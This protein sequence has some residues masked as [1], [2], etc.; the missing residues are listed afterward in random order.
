MIDDKRPVEEMRIEKAQNLADA[1]VYANRQFDGRNPWWRGH[2]LS[3]WA[4]R[5]SIYRV[6]DSGYAGDSRSAIKRA[7]AGMVTAAWETPLM[8]L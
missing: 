2:S 6:E 1:A 4:L 5:P 3:S 7:E 8:V